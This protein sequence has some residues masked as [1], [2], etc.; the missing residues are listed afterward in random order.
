[1]IYYF[2]IIIIRLHFLLKHLKHF[3]MKLW[4]LIPNYPQNHAITSTNSEE[5]S[6]DNSWN[7]GHS[8]LTDIEE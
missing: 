1:M 3:K 6:S 8:D 7:S 4:L 5:Q 2:I